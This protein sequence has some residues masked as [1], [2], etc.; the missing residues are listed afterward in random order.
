MELKL[1]E[2]PNNAHFPRIIK[3][4]NCIDYY[5]GPEK[6]YLV[7]GAD[8]KTV[9][10]WD[11]QNKSCVQTLE[12]HS[13]NITVVCFHPDL[14]VIITGS[15]DGTVRIWH[16][17]TYRLT[18]TLNYGME[19]IWCLGFMRVTFISHLINSTSFR[20]SSQFHHTFNNIK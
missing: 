20:L 3:G 18:N 11:Y 2:T 14:P 16:A 10:I 6:P 15:E 13:Q 19:R 4:V 12:G 8:D 7:S 5:H 1:N 9:K 17:N